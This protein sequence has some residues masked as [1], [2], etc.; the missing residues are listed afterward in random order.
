MK[1]ELSARVEKE[2]LVGPEEGWAS[3]SEQWQELQGVGST[4]VSYVNDCC[5]TSAMC[6]MTKMPRNLLS[7]SLFPVLSEI[8]F[9]IDA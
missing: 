4:H 6:H 7:G 5:D 3:I 8:S 9:S 1:I 2:E